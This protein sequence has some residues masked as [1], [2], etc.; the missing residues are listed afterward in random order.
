MFGSN[1]AGGAVGVFTRQITH[2]MRIRGA[3]G[4]N[5]HG[6]ITDVVDRVPGEATMDSATAELFITKLHTGGLNSLYPFRLVVP[7][8][9]AFI[10]AFD[11]SI[12]GYGW[13]AYQYTGLI[14]RLKETSDYSQLYGPNRIRNQRTDAEL[15]AQVEDCRIVNDNFMGGFT[16]FQLA[17]RVSE[18]AHTAPKRRPGEVVRNAMVV[19]DPNTLRPSDVSFRVKNGEVY[20]ATALMQQADILL[21]EVDTILI[22]LKAAKNITNGTTEIVTYATGTKWWL[23]KFV[24]TQLFWCQW[25]RWDR[26]D[27]Y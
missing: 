26:G 24:G 6:H 20:P 10:I 5:A 17:L 18:Y 3:P 23:D 15:Q 8:Q 12:D 2:M 4:R 1:T 7:G 14:N 27:I 22:K 9:S 11:A 19:E 16:A 25:A 21:S 13:T